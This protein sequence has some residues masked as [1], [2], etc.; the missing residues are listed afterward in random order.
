MYRPVRGSGGDEELQTKTGQEA[1]FVEVEPG[2]SAGTGRTRIKGVA[3]NLPRLRYVAR[4]LRFCVFV[5]YL[6]Q[7]RL[8]SRA[9]ALIID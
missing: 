1:Q 2:F 4:R 5:D 6:R 9:N 8:D 3:Q 7:L